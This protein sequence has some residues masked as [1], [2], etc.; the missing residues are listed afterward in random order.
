MHKVNFYIPIKPLFNTYG[1]ERMELNRI[2]E[3]LKNAVE[4]RMRPVNILNCGSP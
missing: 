4:Q 2:Q 1:W 3:V